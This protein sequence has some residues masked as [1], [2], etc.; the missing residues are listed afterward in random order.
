MREYPKVAIASVGI[1]VIESDRVLLIKR[2]SA[3][4]KGLWAIPGGVI[5][6]G[7]T[8]CEAAKRELKEETN[9]DAKITGV[10]HVD[11]II[12]RDIDGRV[13]YHYVLIDVLATDV[14]GE[15]RAS[16][17]ALEVKW[18]SIDEALRLENL[19]KHTRK[20]LTK[21]SKKDLSLL[22]IDCT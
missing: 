11:Q 17:D 10:I 6:A 22:P 12:E 19:S 7:E 14:K 4:G 15:I 21:L 18:F 20:L 5:E 13:R 9:L 3:P 2:A 16:S 1:V 8:I